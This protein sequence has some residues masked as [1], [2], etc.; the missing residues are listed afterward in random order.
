M[1]ATVELPPEVMD[2]VRQRAKYF[3]RGVDEAVAYYL[4]KG[5]AISPGPPATGPARVRT[6][7]A[8]GLPVVVGSPTAPAR[9]MSA[10]ALV[11]LEHE[12]QTLDDLEGY[13]P[14]GTGL[15]RSRGKPRERG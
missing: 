15:N 8:T 5:L 3:G 2:E 4:V 12:T 1:K 13:P 9:G 7:P 6:D 11:D 14:P 10:A